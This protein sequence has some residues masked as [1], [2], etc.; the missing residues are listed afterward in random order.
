MSEQTV[1][2]VSAAPAARLRSHCPHCGADDVR[3]VSLMYEQATSNLNFRAL[4]MDAAG[5]A[6][7]TA[8]QG[9]LQNLMGGRL[10]PPVVP[11]A[12]VKPKPPIISAIWTAFWVYFF[13]H[14]TM[15]FGVSAFAGLERHTLLGWAGVVFI[16]AWMF[17]FPVFLYLYM[18]DMSNY[19]RAATTY[20]DVLLPQYQAKART[21]SSSWVCM[22]CGDVFVP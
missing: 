3:K 14:G 19:R 21:W 18:V 15:K 2:A 1:Q 5:G 12:P 7:Y 6:G 16:L 11:A 22:R 17:S 4:S 20:H 10:A 9:G 8:G 13:F